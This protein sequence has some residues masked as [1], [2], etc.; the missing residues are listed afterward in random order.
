MK[1]WIKTA[2]ILSLATLVGIQLIHPARNISLQSS[3]KEIST[4]FTVPESTQQVIQRD[5]YDCHSNNTRYP[6]YAYVQLVGWWLNHHITE[7][8]HELN[9][10]E[11]ASY[12]PR[13]QYRKFKAIENEIRKGDL[14][15][16]SY[17]II[18]R[19]AI[20]SEDQ[21]SMFLT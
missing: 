9:F 1:H 15:L 4:G 5:C 12:P 18:H 10:G 7:G 8:K 19:E 11:F 2:I 16:G 6:W 13:K 17:L 14:P 21:K 20:L 3:G